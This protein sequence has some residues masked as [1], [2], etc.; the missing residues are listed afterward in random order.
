MNIRQWIEPTFTQ[1]GFGLEEENQRVTPEGFLAQTDHPFG[2]D[3]VLDRDFC[4]SQLEI[5]T[6]VHKSPREAAEAL[7]AKRLAAA[8]FLAER[9]DPEWLW[10]FSNP[11]YLRSEDDIRIARFT[12]ERAEKTRYRKYLAGKYGKKKQSLCGIHF[13]FSYPQAFLDQLG[14]EGVS[15]DQIYLNLAE[16][17]LAYAWLVVAL[18]AASPLMDA[19]FFG[20]EMGESQA[21]RYSSYRCS[22]R[23]YWN[24]FEPVLDFDAIPNYLESMNYYVETGKLYSAAELYYPV[25]LKPAGVNDLDKLREGVDHIEL[26]MLDV[27]PLRDEG[28]DPGDLDFLTLLL[29]YLTGRPKMD[30]SVMRQRRAMRNMKQAAAYPLEEV[31]LFWIDGRIHPLPRLALQILRDMEAVLGE[32]EAISYQIQKIKEPDRRYT[33]QIL[34]RYS[35]DYVGKGLER[36][37]ELARPREAAGDSGAGRGL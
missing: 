25:R 8:R 3:P 29:L 6:G 4:E 14:R 31:S 17:V 37:Q 30:L 32:H 33:N 24:T 12:G 22:D 16:K 21:G 11:P 36:A 9:E 2:A 23:G 27:N 7:G 19:S 28:I 15:A 26:R 5:I 13:N 34:R 1:G 20:G 10:P 35:R 18:T